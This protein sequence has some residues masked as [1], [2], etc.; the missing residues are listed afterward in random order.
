MTVKHPL[1]L[2]AQRTPHLYLTI[3]VGDMKISELA[4][5]DDIFKI[6]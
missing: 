2:W 6:R 3:E 1:V 5:H 4:V